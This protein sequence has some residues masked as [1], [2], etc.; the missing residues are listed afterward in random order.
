MPARAALRARSDPCGLSLG[1]AGRPSRKNRTHSSQV[2]P[3]ASWPRV[4]AARC[5]EFLA[6]RRG[7][8]GN[9]HTTQALVPDSYECAWV[10]FRIVPAA[11]D[12]WRIPKAEPSGLGDAP[13]GPLS[14]NLLCVHGSV[15]QAAPAAVARGLVRPV[16]DGATD[17]LYAG[18]DCGAYE[19]DL[20]ATG[21]Y[22]AIIGVGVGG[23]ICIGR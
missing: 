21:H 23:S 2:Q 9:T 6:E 19:A 5:V 14:I 11:A 12:A 10:V 13:R 15:E 1:E 8:H 17:V 20:W 22:E 3:R 16:V 7:Q 4:R 18:D